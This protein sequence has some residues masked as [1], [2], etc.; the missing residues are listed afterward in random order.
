M[1]DMKYNR[2]FVAVM[3]SLLVVLMMVFSMLVNAKPHH[4]HH[5]KAKVVRVVK[6]KKHHRHA[7]GTVVLTRPA[8]GRY[9]YQ[10][11]RRYW[12]A[13]NVLYDIVPHK[14]GVRYVVIK[15]I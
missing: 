14:K 9:H 7:K 2:K 13:D 11:N 4:K 8:H 6:H 10:G 1:K 15:V 12:L 5:R 3:R